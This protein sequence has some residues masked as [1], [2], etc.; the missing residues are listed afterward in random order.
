MKP[1]LP[2]IK[3]EG[4]LRQYLN[5]KNGYNNKKNYDD[6]EESFGDLEIEENA[7]GILE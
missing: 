3:E 2:V 6:E 1:T 4:Q 7:D 5:N